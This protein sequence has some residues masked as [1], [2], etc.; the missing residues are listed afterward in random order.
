MLKTESIWTI[1]PDYMEQQQ[2]IMENVRSTLVDWII[3]THYNFNL[4]PESLFLTINIIDRYF[5]KNQITNREVQLVGVS[6]MLIATKYE[7]IYPPLL[8]DF[9]YISDN[10][11]LAEDILEMEK[12]ILFSLDFDI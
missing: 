5:S 10:R 3:Q 12:K 7:E 4:L 2:R 11:C 1:N 6:A 8:K 9:V